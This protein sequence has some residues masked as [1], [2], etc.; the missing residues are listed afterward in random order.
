KVGDRDDLRPLA[1]PAERAAD[2]VRR[3]AADAGVDL[4]EDHRRPAAD[5][6]DRERDAREL[7]ARGRLG[8]RR[9]R[10]ARVGTQEERDAVGAVRPGL[11]LG[12]LDAELALAE[13]DVAEL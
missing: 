4:V 12:E 9:E 5:S 8:D 10:Q 13:R 6:R 11:G 7:P 2:G 3:L 1:E